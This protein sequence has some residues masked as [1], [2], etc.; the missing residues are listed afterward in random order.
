MTNAAAVTI[1]GPSG[2]GKGTIGRRLATIL[3]WH[4]LDSG[5]LYRVLALAA[6]RQSLALDDAPAIAGLA[7]RV[8]VE[9]G[10]ADEVFLDGVDV[11]AELRTETCGNAASQIA[12]LGAVRAALLAWQRAF[13][14]PPGVVADGRDMGTV[15]FPDAEVKIFLTASA[16]E[17]ADR[18]Y[19]QLK[20]KGLSVTLADLFEEIAARD[21]RDASRAVAPLRPAADAFVLDS[22]GIDI[23]GV[24]DRVL[25]QVSRAHLIPAHG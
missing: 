16:E 20:E 21:R 12:A 11:S 6:M 7:N 8:P 13:R 9:F 23:D 14:K 2:S 1:D 10:L 25:E 3:G 19:K 4:F 22:T 18:R 15:V 24:V 5:A 17:R